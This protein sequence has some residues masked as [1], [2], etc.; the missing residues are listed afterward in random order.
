MRRWMIAA[1]YFCVGIPC[2][3]VNE[4]ERLLV[5]HTLTGSVVA[6]AGWVATF[7]VCVVSF[8]HLGLE[9]CLLRP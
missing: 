1:S 6:G 8:Q 3:A 7:R 2:V 9:W 5:P 4:F